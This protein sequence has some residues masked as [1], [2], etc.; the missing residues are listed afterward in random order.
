MFNGDTLVSWRRRVTAGAL[1][2]AAAGLLA[3]GCT[4]VGEPAT[5]A[6]GASGAP[7]AAP[8]FDGD[9]LPFGPDGFGRIT[10]GM[11]E[12]DALLTGDLE[13]APIST[14]L[15]RNVYSFV[16]GPKPDPSRMAADVELE[17]K[18]AKADDPSTASAKDAGNVAQLYADSTKRTLERMHAYLEA[19]GASFRGGYLDNIA[20]PK[21]AVTAEGI[22]RGSSRADLE[23]AYE[24]LG[25]AK[26]G[27]GNYK[28]PAGRDWQLIFEMD[29]DK[30][31]YMSLARRV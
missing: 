27:D 3:A 17:A 9:P 31:K 1:S 14:V 8:V 13:A 19:G 2:F 23:A 12:E 6:S 22:K 10:V 26:G 30:V 20:A 28:M 29:R 5:A 21:D 15:H 16:G 11:K 25:L 18:V 24:N 7:V 4:P